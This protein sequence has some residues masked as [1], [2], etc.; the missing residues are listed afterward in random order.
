LTVS[1]ISSRR[2]RAAG[3]GLTLGLAVHL[4]GCS[5]NRMSLVG[6]PMA[7]PPTIDRLRLPAGG[8]APP[9]LSPLPTPQ[10]VV[11]AMALGRR[12]PF[13]PLPAPPLPTAGTAAGAP[14]GSATATATASGTTAAAGAATGVAGSP[15]AGASGGIPPGRASGAAGIAVLPP[16]PRLPQGFRFSG[17]IRSGGRTEAVVQYG[18]LSGSLRSG[19]RGG[20]STELLPKGWRV[21]SV[22]ADRGQ[23]RLRNAGRLLTVEM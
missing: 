1:A 23:L 14:S 18:D 8:A 15:A 2:A 4:S 6:A 16:L 3:L 17:V 13:A 19:D 11:S 20:I 9:G 5:G 12:D 22:D 7:S 10:Q 21:E